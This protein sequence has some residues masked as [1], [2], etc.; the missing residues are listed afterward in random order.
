MFSRPQ[1]VRSP[2]NFAKKLRRRT[3]T[4]VSTTLLVPL[5][6]SQLRDG[7]HER[8]EHC[9]RESRCASPALDGAT[10]VGVPARIIH[11]DESVAAQRKEDARQISLVRSSWDVASWGGPW[12]TLSPPLQSLTPLLSSQRSRPQ[13]V[14]RSIR[15]C[16]ILERV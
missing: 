16:I 3:T 5:R 15:A 2:A 11:R 7:N 14:K 9:E 1:K 12:R 8:Y 6:T 4:K 10:A 13:C